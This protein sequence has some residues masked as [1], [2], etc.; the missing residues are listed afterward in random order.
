MPKFFQKYKK[1]LIA[2][3]VCLSLIA[4][5]VIANFVA[6]SLIPTAK[7]ITSA[8]SS[9]F[10][11]Y[12]ISLSK[13]QVKSEAETLAKDYQQ[14]GAGGY[15]WQIDEYYHVISSA[16]SNKNDAVLVQNSVKNKGIE[17]ELV[18]VSFP[19]IEIK[20]DFS[21]SES[22]ILNKSLSCFQSYYLSLYDISISYDTLVYNEISARLA[23]NNAHSTLSSTL[24]DFETIFADACEIEPLN[25]FHNLLENALSSSKSL[26]SAI[27]LFPEQT[28]SSLIKYRYLEILYL[29]KNFN[30]K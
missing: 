29:Y 4:C 19:S 9:P 16:Y 30:S 7:V 21:E 6:S 5:L 18:K 26:C 2:S 12:M 28:Y 1:N 8:K 11:L 10:E 27:P 13:S 22:K 24:A 3:F 23:I 15:I 14:I 17:S 20:G 25:S